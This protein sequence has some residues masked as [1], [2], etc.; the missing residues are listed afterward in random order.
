MTERNFD[1]YCINRGL[2][3]VP[4]YKFPNG[5]GASIICQPGSDGFE[6]GLFEL[7]VLKFSDD[8][9]YGFDLVY[10]TPITNDVLGFLNEDQVDEVLA[11]ITRLDKD[12]RLKEDDP[13]FSTDLA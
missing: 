13:W 8:A 3:R 1:E 6:E 11:A 5:Y 9:R 2:F 10:D 7:A 4:K 12:G